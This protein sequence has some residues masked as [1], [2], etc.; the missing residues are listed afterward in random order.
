MQKSKRPK[1]RYMYQ[2]TRFSSNKLK[3][4][5]RQ[6]N[7][8]TTLTHMKT[9]HLLFLLP[10]SILCSKSTAQV[11]D[12]MR[13][14]DI[15]GM[16]EVYN[17]IFTEKKVEEKIAYST[18]NI[19]NL[20]VGNKKK[21]SIPEDFALQFLI[22]EA[23]KENKLA[24]YKDVDCKILTSYKDICFLDSVSIEV[25][26]N[27]SQSTIIKKE[28]S[29]EDIYFF[30]V[31]QIIYYDD[32]KTQFGL[33]TLAIA[34]MIK[35]FDSDN[36]HIGWK[37]IFWM[38]AMDLSKKPQ[39]SDTSIIWGKSLRQRIDLRSDSVRNL[40]KKP[41]GV[42]LDTLCQAITNKPNI[43]FYNADF[44][45]LS[46]E[47]RMKLIFMKDT[48]SE[49]DSVTQKMQT[50]I[51]NLKVGTDFFTNFRIVQ[52]WYWDDKTKQLK[53]WLWGTAPFK[54]ITNEAGELLYW[55]P[56]CYRL[57]DD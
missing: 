42:A 33:R 40:N 23:V 7:L 36:Q 22:I 8:P 1:V 28:L 47:E 20:E 5:T 3:F 9:L 55:T 2:S 56:F 35:D 4:T 49:I 57:N 51:I 44:V 53:I 45:K 19:T 50:F 29:N 38:K 15:T 17:N 11:D 21:T 14:K 37:P 16:I 13:N 46:M 12:L 39:F 30:R 32:E 54:K 41:F 18:Y 27:K 48:I 6:I 10:L 52:H 25:N 31:K 24:I 34:P 43:S 26:N